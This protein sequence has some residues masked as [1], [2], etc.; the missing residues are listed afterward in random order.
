MGNPFAKAEVKLE[1]HLVYRPGVGDVRKH[2]FD[3]AF[4]ATDAC[5]AMAKVYVDDSVEM[6]NDG[7]QQLL[8]AKSSIKKGQ[9]IEKSVLR[10]CDGL[11]D[12]VP[13]PFILRNGTDFSLDGV[14]LQLE[15]PYIAA[16]AIMFYA[17]S[18]NGDAN[19]ELKM[20]APNGTSSLEVDVVA[21]VDIE[22]GTK[23][24][25]K[26]ADIP[27]D[28]AYG[29]VYDM[30]EED[31][32]AWLAM[33]A[34]NDIEDAA[35]V[36]G[37]EVEELH[38]ET[39]R[40]HFRQSR[41]GKIAPF[42]PDTPVGVSSSKARVMPHPVWPGYGV[43]ATV[44]IKKGEI[45][46]YGLHRKIAGLNGDKCPYV[47]TW[48][49]NGK[50]RKQEE[51]PNQWA[52]G[53]GNIMFYNSD[54]PPNC[55][56]FR[57]YGGWRFVLVARQDIAMGEEL[58]HLYKSSSWRKCFVQD[59]YLPKEQPLE[60]RSVENTPVMAP[61]GDPEILVNGSPIPDLPDIL[62]NDGQWV[63]SSPRPSP[64]ASPSL[65]PATS[66]AAPGDDLKI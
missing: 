49:P 10:A 38:E 11:D 55:R 41:E 21:L 9:V 61:K 34:G 56:L 17:F 40:D 57:L 45:V 6:R 44:N 47:F 25:R 54:S 42:V 53:A 51:G 2:S 39:I 24:V 1:D 19:V 23:F 63:R 31:L 29:D 36:E 13:N 58:M 33:W 26:G 4:F 16:G 52:Q 43:F 35:S 8:F 14:E 59:D 64:T 30:P 65:E 22:A 7:G 62:L 18:P 15:A 50:R 66:P 46:E 28:V 60:V 20:S 27:V 5:R 3:Q 32:N 12:S 48:N 37:K